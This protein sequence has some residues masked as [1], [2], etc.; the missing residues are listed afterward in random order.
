MAGSARR[1]HVY[2]WFLITLLVVSAAGVAYPLYVIRPFRHQGPRELA[3]ALAVIQIRSIVEAICLILALAGLAWYWRLE[4]GRKQRI[5]A[6]VGTGFV[7]AFAVL[8]HVNLY[9]LMFHPDTHPLF[10]SLQQVKIDSDDKV[11]AVKL[12]GS[13]RAYPIRTI[14][15]HHIINDVVGNVPIVATY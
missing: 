10:A 2:S 4:L 7:C 1:K 6:T 8:S 12:G 3:A 5:L 9:E 15:Y 11:L 13:A 14:A